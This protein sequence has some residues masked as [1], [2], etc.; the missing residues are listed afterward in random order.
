MTPSLTYR[1]Q[2]HEAPGDLTGPVRPQEAC[3]SLP[4]SML[5]RMAALS[6]HFTL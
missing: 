3:F 4:L 2:Q 6:S 1:T 5:P